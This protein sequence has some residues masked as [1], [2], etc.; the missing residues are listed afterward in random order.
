MQAAQALR[1]R[2][3]LV[4]AIRP[5]TVPDGSARLRLTFSAAHEESDI[6]RLAATVKE[7]VPVAADAP[8]APTP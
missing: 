7:V 5:P 8:G 3:F 2:G 1:K 6:D 4:G